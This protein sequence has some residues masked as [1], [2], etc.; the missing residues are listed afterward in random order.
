[1]PRQKGPACQIGGAALEEDGDPGGYG[2]LW[3]V[4]LQGARWGF[5]QMEVPHGASK[6]MVSTGKYQLQ[7]DVLGVPPFQET[8]ISI[9]SVHCGPEHC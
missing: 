5:S 1:M 3:K 6:W 4:R 2:K 8:S 9:I 7:M